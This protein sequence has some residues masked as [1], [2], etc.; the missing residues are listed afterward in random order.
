LFLAATGVAV[1]ATVISW[2][3]GKN[4]AE[5]LW[6]RFLSFMGSDSREY[7]EKVMS[8]PVLQQW[9]DERDLKAANALFERNDS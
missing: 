7:R 1:F 4:Y 2:F 8:D 6:I 5:N 3:A 9:Y